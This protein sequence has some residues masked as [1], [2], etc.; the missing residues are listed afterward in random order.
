VAID[1]IG[2]DQIGIAISLPIVTSAARFERLCQVLT[3]KNHPFRIGNRCD[4]AV[5]G[6]HGHRRSPRLRLHEWLPRQRQRNG[7]AN[8]NR[9]YSTATA[10]ILGAFLNLVG[11]C[12]STAVAKPISRGFLDDQ[13][14]TAR[15]SWLS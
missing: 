5:R 15:S 12:L 1:E 13:L 4:R 9:S 11:A 3:D 7:R 2:I 10:V 8:H 14:I 6:R